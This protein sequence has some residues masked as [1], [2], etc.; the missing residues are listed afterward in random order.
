MNDHTLRS[1]IVVAIF[2]GTV[3]FAVVAVAVD[4]SLQSS[5]VIANLA[6]VA[7][8]ALLTVRRPENW[9]GPLLVLW[10]L[11]VVANRR[12]KRLRH[13]GD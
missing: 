10:L 2:G 12:A 8:G 13:E 9:I 4:R 1:R 7:V 11:L 3:V 6:F 5:Q